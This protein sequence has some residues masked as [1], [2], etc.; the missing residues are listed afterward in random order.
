MYISI[1]L[2]IYIY[3]HSDVARGVCH[4][5]A[6]HAMLPGRM[7]VCSLARAHEPCAVQRC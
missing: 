2:Y 7:L 4:G 3:I 6:W 5:V 1:Y